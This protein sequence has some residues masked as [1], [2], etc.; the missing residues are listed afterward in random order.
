MST[1]PEQRP[2][3]VGERYRE[4]RQAASIAA[5]RVAAEAP[6]P[7]RRWR[8]DPAGIARELNIEVLT[9]EGLPA[10]A[11]WI[12]RREDPCGGLWPQ[13]PRER[14]VIEVRPDLPDATRRFAIAH[15]VGHIYFHRHLH[16]AAGWLTLEGQERFANAF[17]AE[18]LIPRA[19]R[20]RVFEQFRAADDPVAMLRLAGSLGVSPRAL[21]RFAA[22]NGWL[23]GMDRV[24][25]DVRALPNRYT[26]RDRRLRIYDAVLDRQRWF[27]PTNRS[28]RGV[29]G[30]DRW[31]VRASYVPAR[32]RAT[33]E[34]ARRI[35]APARR[36]ESCS[37]PAEVAGVRLRRSQAVHG[38][39]FLATANLQALDASAR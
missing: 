10:R 31:L 15:E 22:A 20:Q 1:T 21:M 12:R 7:A 38:M 16:H 36:F 6:V 5:L 14:D 3:G 27:L 35:P 18:I 29:L 4:I 2:T 11:R 19:H 37:V 39:E 32:T 25:L 28:L 33:V 8:A 9:R 26:N 17:A 24:W 34:I 30:V 23:S 13:V